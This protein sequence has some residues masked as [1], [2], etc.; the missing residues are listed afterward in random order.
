[1]KNHLALIAVT[2]LGLVTVLPR[3]AADHHEDAAEIKAL[4][5]KS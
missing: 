5:E 2:I 4:I 1:M 3:A